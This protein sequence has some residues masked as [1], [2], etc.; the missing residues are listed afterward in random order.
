MD[1]TGITSIDR[2]EAFRYMGFRGKTPDK[3]FLALVDECEKEI[4]K[5]ARP[6]CVFRIFDILSRD[7]G[8]HLDGASLVLTGHN[9]QNL[10]KNSSRAAV[11]AVTLGAGVD[12]LIRRME[13]KDVT[14]GF[15]TDF[16]ASAMVEQLCDRTEE[17]IL[18]NIDEGK[19]LTTRFSCGYGDLPLSLQKDFLAS[20]NASR[21]IGLCVTDTSIMTPR[22]SVTAV[23][24]VLD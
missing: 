3:S 1:I 13:T 20:L 2:K 24:G 11:F 12:V 18:K 19:R 7:E 4:L 10:L 23:A 14:L 22:K 5:V 6:K 8:I 16:L 21:Q 9:I 15:I 17:E